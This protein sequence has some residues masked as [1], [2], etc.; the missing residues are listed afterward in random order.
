MGICVIHTPRRH[1]INLNFTPTNESVH[2]EHSLSGIHMT[3][4]F[5]SLIHKGGHDKF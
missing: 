1:C 3:V 5:Y 4:L 2:E